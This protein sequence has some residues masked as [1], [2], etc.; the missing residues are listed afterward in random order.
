ME[1]PYIS[2][3]AEEQECVRD[4]KMSVVRYTDELDLRKADYKKEF[5][6]DISFNLHDNIHADSKKMK[7][8]VVF[9]NKGCWYF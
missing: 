4:H 5:P 8:F 6:I 2:G 7:V 1:Q 3:Q 9:F